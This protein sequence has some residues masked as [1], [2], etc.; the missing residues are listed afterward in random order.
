MARPGPLTELREVCRDLE[1]AVLAQRLATPEELDRH[2]PRGPANP[3][4]GFRGWLRFHGVLHRCHAKQ[5]YGAPGPS[6]ETLLA[7][8]VAEQP[9]AVQLSILGADGQPRLVYCHPKSHRAL[10]H[11]HARDVRAAKWMGDFRAVQQM[12]AAGEQELLARV[13]EQLDDQLRILVWIAITPGAW[14]PF[15]PLVPSP[16]PPAWLSLLTAED[17]ALILYAFHQVNSVRVG[18]LSQLLGGLTPS[19]RRQDPALLGW[20]SFIVQTG[21]ALGVEPETLD[22]DRSLG[23]VLASAYIRAKAAEALKAEAA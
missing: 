5:E 9:R 13:A 4:Q 15:D 6:A 14:L 21:E 10:L 23:F 7:A 16:E 20:A 3:E 18:L 11:M 17:V 1:A 2:R 19:E 12:P 8:A 22:R